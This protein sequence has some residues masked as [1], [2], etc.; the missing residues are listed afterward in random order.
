MDGEFFEDKSCDELIEEELLGTKGCI[1][2]DETIT[3]INELLFVS[4]NHLKLEI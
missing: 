4:L 1:D 2:D 3:D